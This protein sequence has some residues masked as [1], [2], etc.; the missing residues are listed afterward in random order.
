MS[1][2]WVKVEEGLPKPYTTVLA[3]LDQVSWGGNIVYALVQYSAIGNYFTLDDEGIR[4]YAHDDSGMY[5]ELEGQVVEWAEI[6]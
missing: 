3:K 2:K 5:A 6:S 1:L 4:F